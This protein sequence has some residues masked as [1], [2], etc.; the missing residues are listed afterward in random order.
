MKLTLKYFI[1]T[2]TYVEDVS[3]SARQGNDGDPEQN[4]S[5]KKSCYDDEPE[6]QEDERL[7]VEDV[8]RQD[9]QEIAA[10]DRSRRTELVEG[11]LGDSRE[12]VDHRVDSLALL[13]V[14]ELSHLEAVVHKLS[15]EE[16]VH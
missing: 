13:H 7:F 4:E 1:S 8:Q 10:D 6:P 9:A 11:T 16:G 3:T 12:D 14:R 2:L 5:R 15:V